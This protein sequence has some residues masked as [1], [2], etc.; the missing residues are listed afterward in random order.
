MSKEEGPSRWWHRADQAVTIIS[1]A[2][3]KRQTEVTMWGRRHPS[4]EGL[5]PSTGRNQ[6]AVLLAGPL[7]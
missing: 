3:R 7:Q 4:V 1:A 6:S 5:G 2:V